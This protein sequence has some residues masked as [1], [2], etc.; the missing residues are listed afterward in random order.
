[1]KRDVLGL[2]SAF[3]HRSCVI[4]RMSVN[5]R[6]EA[7]TAVYGAQDVLR[8]YSA[9]EINKNVED[10]ISPWIDVPL[11]FWSERRRRSLA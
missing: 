10:L 3:D 6:I 4:W 1:M 8:K 9:A 5:L 7:S 11:V 2:D